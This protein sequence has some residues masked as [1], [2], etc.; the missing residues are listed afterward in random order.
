M[1][2]W[3]DSVVPSKW[4]V[5]PR[6]S[7]EAMCARRGR[8]EVIAGC[9]GILEGRAVDDDLILALG[10]PHAQRVLDGYEGGRDGYWPRVWAAR[11]LL[12]VFDPVA[13]GAV[14]RAG[15]DDAWRVREMTAKVVAA[16]R[17][18]E[19]AQAVAGLL[20]DPVA[21]VRRAAERALKRLVG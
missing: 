10:G 9:I 2:M 8:E 15:M 19:A 13:T 11:G 21:R 6:Q 16:H 17:V 3:H 14:I 1:V 7:I 20:D 18:D 5:T 12:H 4:G